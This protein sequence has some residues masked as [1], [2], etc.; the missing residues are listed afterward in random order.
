MSTQS[1]SI[2]PPAPHLCQTCAVAHQPEQPHDPTSFFYVTKFSLETGRSPTWSDGMAH[3]E[4]PVKNHWAKYLTGI[5]IDINSTQVR[6]DLK[7]TEE[8]TE[9][10]A[11]LIPKLIGDA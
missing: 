1:F 3:C 9:R 7:T 2:L 6:G 10:M 8:L 5:G 11:K 4:D